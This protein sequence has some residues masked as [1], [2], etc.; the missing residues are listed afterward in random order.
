MEF[1][2]SKVESMETFDILSPKKELSPIPAQSD[3]D[4]NNKFCLL[5]EKSR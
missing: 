5:D 2:E 4:V 3:H 1:V